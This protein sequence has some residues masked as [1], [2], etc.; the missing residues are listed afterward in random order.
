MNTNFQEFATKYK[1][2]KNK[3]EQCMSDHIVPN[4]FPTYS[5][6]PKGQHYSLYCKFQLLTS[7]PW[8]NSINDAWGTTEPDDQTYITEWHNFLNTAYAKK[9]V[10]NWSQKIS[11]V[12][13]N[14]QLPVYEHSDNQE[15][16]QQEEW[17]ILSDF[18]K[19]GEQSNT[20][21]LPHS[22]YDWTIDSMKYTT[23]QIGTGKSYLIRALTSYL[24]H[25]CVITATT[26]K[27]AY[28]ISGVTIHS[29]L[30]LPITPQSER[31]LSGEALI[32]LQHRLCNVDYILID[33]YSMLGQKTLGWID[34]R[35]RQSS[36]VKEHLFGGK[37]IILIGDPAQL[38]PVGDKPFNPS[39]LDDGIVGYLHNLSP[40][41]TS[42]N[43]NQY[44][45]LDFQTNSTVYRTV[46]FSAEK[47]ASLKRKFECSSPVKVNKYNLK[48]N[49]KTGEEELIWNK[50]TKI[51]EPQ[52]SEMEFD[53]QPIK[54]ETVEAKDSSAKEILGEQ[55][56]TLV[57][58]AGRVTLNG[59]TET[60]KV[61]G[62]T[63]KK[64]EALFTDNT[65]SVRLVLWEQDTT[66]MQSG[67][68]YSMTNV[69]VKDYNGTN[70]LTL[71]KHT[72]VNAAEL[73]VDR[74]D[75]GVD[76][77]KQMQVAFPPEG[78]NYVQQYLSCNKCQAKVM[79]SP[80]KIIKCSECELTQLKSKCSSKIIAS[81]L[82]K[83][84]KDTMS[85]NIFDNII[86]ELYTLYKEQDGDIDKLFTELTDDDVT[87]I[88]LTVIFAT[89]IF[90]DKKNA[91][92][93]IKL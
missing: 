68:C 84:D 57:N 6:N 69:A 3:L 75:V 63:L 61:K 49:D 25:K 71:T 38:P 86:E 91:S 66:K 2:T 48:K 10:Q 15:Q 20:A 53:L 1:L 34:R 37:S 46:C 50:R 30:K 79:D 40:I 42:Q 87:E 90:N 23:Q 78:I 54:A 56:K 67:Q 8:K 18:Y 13:D 22:N 24:Q 80:K 60:V 9:H 7:K 65:G 83:T 41:K 33:E 92:T 19:S 70:Y 77:G 51:E 89:V 88:L 76:D 43:K 64:Q 5:S 85:L 52:E 59:P 29:L 14:I 82:T 11:D 21:P 28:S 58:I 17:M 81:I 16:H 31:D 44:F 4:I 45:V 55:I 39:K 72:K 32:E 73:Q 12:L 93:V 27:A 74:Q 47:H 36:G 35:C 26:G 62:K